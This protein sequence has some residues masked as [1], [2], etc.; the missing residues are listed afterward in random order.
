MRIK[1]AAALG[2]LLT[3]A[4]I[5]RPTGAIA[6][7]DETVT[8]TV[9]YDDLDL[10]TAK[11]VS[12]LRERIHFLA[13]DACRTNPDFIEVIAGYVDDTP[14]TRAIFDKAMAD[15]MAARNASVDLKPVASPVLRLANRAPR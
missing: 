3:L 15:A 12:R 10:S 11:G 4:V 7:S 2:A 14:C 6:Q 5:A 9:H 8:L 13:R 1:S